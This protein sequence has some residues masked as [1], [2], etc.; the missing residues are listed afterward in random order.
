MGFSSPGGGSGALVYSIP[1]TP[2]G[3]PQPASGGI[4]TPVWGDGFNPNYPLTNR[5]GV[6]YHNNNGNN[7][8]PLEAGGSS[9]AGFNND[10]I[11]ILT[12]ERPRLLADGLHLSALYDQTG[13]GANAAATGTISFRSGCLSSQALLPA[14][15]TTGWPI[16]GFY[17]VP[18]AGVSCCFEIAVRLPSSFGADFGSWFTDGSGHGEFD[19]AEWNNYLNP[20]PGLTLGTT[21]TNHDLVVASGASGYSFPQQADGQWHT[22]DFVIDG[23]NFVN[24]TYCDQVAVGSNSGYAWLTAANQ[25]GAATFSNPSMG[26]YSNGL[27]TAATKP[28]YMRLLLSYALRNVSTLNSQYASRTQSPDDVVVGHVAFYQNANSAGVGL[29]YNSGGVAIQGLDPQ[30]IAPG[31]VLL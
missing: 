7:G 25:P 3:I 30:G 1:K 5:W 29:M 15:G 27:P 8:I 12:A 9:C 28:Y 18:V 10:E 2:K 26:T 19:L 22:W 6:N 13:Y 16:R 11:E 31:T 23:V 14:G 21:W 20:G 24:N 4:W 17:F